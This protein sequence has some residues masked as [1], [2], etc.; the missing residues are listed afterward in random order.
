M[1]DVAKPIDR[2]ET[3]R[4]FMIIRTSSVELPTRSELGQ[5]VVVP[6]SRTKGC[7]RRPNARKPRKN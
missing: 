1:A 2:N 3:A 4:I 7:A 6:T 5:A